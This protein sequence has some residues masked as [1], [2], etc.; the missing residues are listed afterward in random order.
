M[1]LE[2]ETPP[3]FILDEVAQYCN[4]ILSSEIAVCEVFLSVAK[5]FCDNEESAKRITPDGLAA[6][7]LQPDRLINVIREL[8]DPDKDD[9]VMYAVPADNLI[10]VNRNDLPDEAVCKRRTLTDAGLPA[11]YFLFLLISLLHEITHLF[12]ES[13]NLFTDNSSKAA[14]TLHVTPE[15]VGRTTINNTEEQDAGIGLELSLFGGIC[16]FTHGDLTITAVKDPT[17]DISV[18]D[19]HDTYEISS[20][21]AIQVVQQIRVWYNSDIDSIGSIFSHIHCKNLPRYTKPEKKSLLDG[22]RTKFHVPHHQQGEKINFDVE[23]LPTGL[24]R[25]KLGRTGIPGVKK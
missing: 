2:L 18:P 12:T 25:K 16:F 22:I 21:K 8:P 9:F 20:E 3:F 7:L 14:G 11:K 17:I 19:N 10:V 24:I 6:I 15:K 4:K 1:R 23:N 5:L 13:L